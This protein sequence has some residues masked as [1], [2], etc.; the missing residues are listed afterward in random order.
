MLAIVW[1][2]TCCDTWEAGGLVPTYCGQM[3]S[4]WA[5]ACRVL[6]GVSCALGAWDC[7]SAWG[8][9]CPGPRGHRLAYSPV[10]QA[11]EVTDTCAPGVGGQRQA[12]GIGMGAEIKDAQKLP[13]APIRPHPPPPEP[14][15]LPGWRCTQ[16]SAQFY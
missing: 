13:W 7:R 12:D 4:P 11:L 3:G 8:Q 16:A 10:A 9:L 1:L 2:S 14:P 5:L 15:D 6:G